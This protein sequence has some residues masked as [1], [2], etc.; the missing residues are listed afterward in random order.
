VSDNVVTLVL[1][2]EREFDPVAQLVLAG[3]GARL[4]LTFESLDDLQ[5]ALAGLVEREES[6]RDLVVRFTIGDGVIATEVGPFE[7]ESLRV[8]LAR[9]DL[10]GV[11][12]RRLLDTMVDSVQLDEDA[13]GVVVRLVKQVGL[14]PTQS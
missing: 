4:G 8:E 2:R 3:I 12:L 13:A 6:E 10:G 9:D 5:L 1:P 14:A 7:A 11:G